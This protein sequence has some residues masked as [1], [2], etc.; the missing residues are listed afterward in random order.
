VEQL[1]HGALIGVVEVMD[2]VPLAEVEGEPFAA[3]PWR[4]PLANPRPS[5][6]VPY[7][8]HIYLFPVPRMIVDAPSAGCTD[9]DSVE[10]PQGRPD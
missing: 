10:A 5:A 4:W 6:P 8:K 7:R 9:Q 3:G 2:C 1:D